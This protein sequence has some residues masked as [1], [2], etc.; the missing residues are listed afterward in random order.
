MGCAQMSVPA[1]RQADGEPTFA[2]FARV[3]IASYPEYGEAENAVNRLSDHGFPVHRLTI[4]GTGLRSVEQ[5]R[6][7]MT[8][9]RAALIGAAGG[10]LLGGLLALVLGVITS[11]LDTALQFL[12][13]VGVCTLFGAVSGALA[14]LGASAGRR[15]FVSVRRV[16]AARYDVQVDVALADE[17]RRAITQAM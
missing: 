5:I 9:R 4:V 14:Q 15:E 1:R 13:T 6:D 8:A 17:A 11:E 12:T 10:V 16:E 7:R 2:T 3:T